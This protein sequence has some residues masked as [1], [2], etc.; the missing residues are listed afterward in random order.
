MTNTG[1]PNM[2]SDAELLDHI[3]DHI[4]NNATDLG[5][6]EWYEPVEHYASQTRFDA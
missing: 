4:D 5:D 6:E 2:L 1:L 3:L